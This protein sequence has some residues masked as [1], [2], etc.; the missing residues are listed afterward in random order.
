MKITM[1]GIPALQQQIKQLKEV[2]EELRGAIAGAALAV[3]KQMKV[4]VQ[5]GPKSGRLYRRGSIK[6]AATKARRALGLR[7][8]AGNPNRVIVGATFHRASAPGEAPASDTGRLVASLTHTIAP[9]GLTATIGVHDVSR[10]KYAPALE[11]GTR[12]MAARPFVVRALR[13]KQEEVEQRVQ[14]GVERAIAKVT[15]R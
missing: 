12:R 5:K 11:F 13:E 10:V 2:R 6:R 3:E 8:V 4:L 9:D 15:Q 14:Q 7:R 1:R